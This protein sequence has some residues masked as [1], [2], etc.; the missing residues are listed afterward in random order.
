M[1]AALTAGGIRSLNLRW[2]PSHEKEGS[3]RITP[4][5]RAGNERADGLA[6]AQAKRIGP[7]AAQGR[8]YDRRTRQLEAVQDIQ[9]R[10]LAAAQATDPPK[11]QGHA[12]RRPRAGPGRSQAQACTRRCHLPILEEGELR[13]WGPHLIK[14]SGTEGFRC[15]SCARV[16]NHKRAR[17][18]LRSL[19]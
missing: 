1:A 7:T 16:A 14:A 18:A 2:V 11:A 10:I 3:D 8:L 9:L 5:D 13:M 6:N 12:A 17:Y 4:S 19:P 15:I